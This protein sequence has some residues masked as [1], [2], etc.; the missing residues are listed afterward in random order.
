MAKPPAPQ[1]WS[2]FVWFCV[3]LL[4]RDVIFACRRTLK[5]L[6]CWWALSQSS[7]LSFLKELNEDVRVATLVR[8]A[9][10][11]KHAMPERRQLQKQ[12][13]VAPEITLKACNGLL[14]PTSRRPKRGWPKLTS[15]SL[16]CRLF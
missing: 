1:R 8:L 15:V 16:E 7:C 10:T 5:I 2:T 14:T 13:T 12:L 4:N 11:K 9:V 6:S 3:R